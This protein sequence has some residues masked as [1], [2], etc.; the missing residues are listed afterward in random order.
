MLIILIARFVNISRLIPCVCYYSFSLVKLFFSW[1]SLYCI[2][3]TYPKQVWSQYLAKYRTC[4]QMSSQ[5]ILKWKCH[6]FLN[7]FVPSA[8]FLYP[9]KTSENRKGREWVEKVC[10]GTNG[11]ASLTGFKIILS[12]ELKFCR[13]THVSR[14]QQFYK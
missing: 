6:W 12:A 14:Q 10:I 7:P 9:L 1:R 2:S 3:E 5:Y 8:P 11:W 4:F 13:L